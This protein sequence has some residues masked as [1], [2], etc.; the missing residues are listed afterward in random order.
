MAGQTNPAPPGVP[1]DAQPPPPLT[2]NPVVRQALLRFSLWIVLALALAIVGVV[3]LSHVVARANTLDE[4]RD[5]TRHIA[6]RVVAPLA[7]EQFRAGDKAAADTVAAALMPRIQDGS[8]RVVKLWGDAGDGRGTVLWSNEEP[9]IGQTF[10]M[11]EEE[12]A[13]F[14]SDDTKAEIS[15]LEKEENALERSQ[16]E[17]VEVYAGLQDATGEPMLFEAYVSTAGIAVDTA[18]LT[19]EM[20][21][22]PILAV[23]LLG[24]VTLPLAVSLAREVDRGQLRMQRMV[25][26]AVA[27]SKLERQR[28]ARDLHDGVIQDLAAVRYTISARLRRGPDQELGEDLTRVSDILRRD[29]TALR[30]LMADI[31][32]A[33]LDRLGL[34]GALR[35]LAR[36]QDATT[37]AEVTCELVEPLPTSSLAVR[38]C[39]RIVRELVRNAIKH[40]DAT[41]IVIR[42][43]RRDDGLWFEVSDDGVGFDSATPASSGHYGLLLTQQMLENSGGRL[44]IASAPG[45]GTVVSGCL[46]VA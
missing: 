30:T 16:G 27:T 39:Y 20:L 6:D 28:I 13:L 31:Y 41:H 38:P 9:L 7:D 43:E 17:L 44:D 11:E 26:A 21:A 45:E 35:Q 19:R 29:L 12:Y 40:A 32:T 46:P 24:A 25:G 22:V 14:G 37:T 5:T 8:F 36:E 42:A 33:D 4:A 10:E 15:S 1:D 2:R 3:A 23:L 34:A 18:T